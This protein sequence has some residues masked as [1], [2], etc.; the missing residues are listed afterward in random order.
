ML[1]KTIHSSTYFISACIFFIGSFFLIFKANLTIN[2]LSYFLYIS[3]LIDALLQTFSFLTKKTKLSSLIRI[4]FDIISALILYFYPLFLQ[5]SVSLIFGIYL[6]LYAI[7]E[8]INYH[9]YKKNKTRGHLLVFL[10]FLI[11]FVLSLFL[12]FHPSAKY[13]YVMLIIGIYFGLYA[14]SQLNSFISEII[15][16]KIKNNVRISIPI[17][18]SAFIPQKLITLIN[19]LLTTEEEVDLQAQKKAQEKK[20]RKA[21]IEVIIHLARSGSASFGHI[22]LSFEGKIYSYGNYDMHSRSLFDAIGDGVIC[23]ADRDAYLN[24]ALTNKKRYLVL[25][26]ITLSKREKEVVK[27]RI[28]KLITTNVIDYYPDLQQAEMGLI[29]Q[30]EYHDMS[31]DIYRYANRKFKKVIKG[32]WKT[33]FV[34]KTNCTGLVDAVLNGVGLCILKINGILTPGSYY[35]FLNQEFLKKQSNVI[36]RKIYTNSSNLS[37]VPLQK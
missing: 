30:K 1:A 18:I 22:E 8:L 7:I 20:K 23:I 5:V 24:Y 25:F 34:L 13:Q 26:G 31:S 21:D 15:S 10:S 17:L 11:R 27:K 29:P 37:E 6:F 3:V 4:L 14:F 12:M 9:L 16:N 19:E 32:K 2:L 33:F 36:Y 35:D 28:H